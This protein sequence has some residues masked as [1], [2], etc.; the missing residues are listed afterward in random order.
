M[1]HYGQSLVGGSSDEEHL[2]NLEA[3]FVQ[4]NGNVGCIDQ[5]HTQVVNARSSPIRAHWQHTLELVAELWKSL[6][7][8]EMSPNDGGNCFAALRPYASCVIIGWRL[9][10]WL[11]FHYHVRLSQWKSSPD[12]L[13]VTNS[14]R[15]RQTLQADIQRNFGDYVWPKTVPLEHLRPSFHDPLGQSPRHCTDDGNSSHL[16]RVAEHWSGN[17]AICEKLR[18]AP[19][20][21]WLW[22]SNLWKRVHVD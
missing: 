5:L 3:V 7:W 9:S 2:R 15:T 13:R 21:P 17:W 8:C 14:E 10:I 4:F 12:C 22:P 6:L 11:G 20:T 18:L 19:L 16:L 1:C